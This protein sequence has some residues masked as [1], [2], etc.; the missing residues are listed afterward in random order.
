MKAAPP[1]MFGIASGMMRTFA[2]VGMVFSFSVAILVASRSISRQLAFAIFVG[3]TSLHGQVADAFTTGLHA[4]FY[5]S[6]IFMVIAAVLSALRAGGIRRPGRS[7]SSLQPAVPD[8]VGRFAGRGEAEF[9]S[10]TLSSITRATPTTALRLQTVPHGGR[11]RR[12]AV[13]RGEHANVPAAPRARG[14]VPCRPE[15]LEALAASG[16]T[17]LAR[18]TLKE[19]KTYVDLLAARAAFEDFDAGAYYGGKGFGFVRVQ[20][21]AIEHLIGARG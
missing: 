18:R 3:T 20:Q 17:G 13:R 15:V 4:A 6:V 10:A 9:A 7:G 14:S 19:G 8:A 12:V 1:D 16:I 21:L 2:N 5:A 11:R